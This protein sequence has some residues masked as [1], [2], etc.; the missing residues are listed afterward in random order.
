MSD[1]KCNR[2]AADRARVAGGEGYKTGYFAQKHE[3]T[4][5]EAKI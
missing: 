2:G 1:D 3:I 5:E 4:A